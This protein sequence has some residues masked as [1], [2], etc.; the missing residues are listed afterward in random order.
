MGVSEKSTKQQPVRGATVVKD[1]DRTCALTTPGNRRSNGFLPKAL[2]PPS[3]PWSTQPCCG[4][5]LPLEAGPKEAGGGTVGGGA[6]QQGMP[7]WRMDPLLLPP[8]PFPAPPS[9]G[10]Q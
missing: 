1:R 6:G 7:P 10:L 3:S 9:Y 8:F 5:P 2:A 4:P